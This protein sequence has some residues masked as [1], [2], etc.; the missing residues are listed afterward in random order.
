MLGD[1]DFAEG[2]VCCS[3]HASYLASLTGHHLV[4]QIGSDLIN[5]LTFLDYF[6]IFQ[7][8]KSSQRHQ[9][10]QRHSCI[11][12]CFQKLISGSHADNHIV[13]EEKQE[14]QREEE[15]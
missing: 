5:L 3:E 10:I 1:A 12:Q 15:T 11:H 6:L 14:Q 8:T 2:T 9:H 7:R 4:L 13:V